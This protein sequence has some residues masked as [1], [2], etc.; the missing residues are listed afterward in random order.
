MYYGLINTGLRA[1]ISFPSRVWA[2]PQPP[3]FRLH[4]GI[5]KPLL[6]IVIRPIYF[7]LVKINTALM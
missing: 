3:L 1:T 4:F 7:E 5:E 2:E 6:V